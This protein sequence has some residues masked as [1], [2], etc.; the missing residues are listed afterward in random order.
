MKTKLVTLLTLLF[1]V[2][3]AFT[4]T[5][6]AA[7]P[8]LMNFQGKATDKSGVPLNGAYNLTFRIYNSGV[9]GT[10]KWSETQANIPISNGTVKQ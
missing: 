6:S 4:F 2:A 9:G 7:I 8:H 1:A 5:A 3:L 10:P